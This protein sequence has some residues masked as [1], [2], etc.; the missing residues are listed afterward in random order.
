M[1]LD[2]DG[3]VAEFYEKPAQPPTTLASCGIYWLP[4]ASRLFLDRY[5]ADGHNSDQPG[6]YMRW[7]AENSSLYA[8][9]LQG[10]WLDIG[11]RNSYERAHELFRQ[12]PKKI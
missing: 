4:A 10:H 3:R 1:R 11:D 5:L 9:P 7:L 8:F 6:H 2:R 12:P